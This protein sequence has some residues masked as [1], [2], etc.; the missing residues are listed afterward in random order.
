MDDHK[1][2]PAPNSDASQLQRAAIEARLAAIDHAFSNQAAQERAGRWLIGAVPPITLL[3][4]FVWGRGP[5]IAAALYGVFAAVVTNYV[6]WTHAQDCESRRAAVRK[7]LD[8]CDRRDAGEPEP[9]R[10]RWRAAGK[11]TRLF[12]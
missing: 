5:A 6:V 4:L 2:S 9:E 7:Q 10:P 11:P 1:P 12:G 8:E 3:V